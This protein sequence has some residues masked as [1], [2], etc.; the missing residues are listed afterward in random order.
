ISKKRPEYGTFTTFQKIDYFFSFICLIILA[1]TGL[2]LIFPVASAA[3]ISSSGLHVSLSIH[4]SF[5]ILFSVFILISHMFNTHLHP[6]K[7]YFNT[8]WLTGTLNEEEMKKHHILTY[9]KIVKQDTDLVEKYE[10][11]AEEKSQEV[12]VKKEQKMLED[13]LK[14]GNA[15]AQSGEYGQAVEKYQEA[16]VIYPNYS[17]AKFNLGVVYKKNDQLKEAYSA[18]K[19]FV[20]MDPFNE[21]A[22]RAKKSMKEIRELL[23]E[24]DK[25][26]DENKESDDEGI[27]G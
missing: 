3:F 22:E 10:K 25:A 23:A 13:Y 26:K 27:N 21:M 19:E 9:N 5:A 7:L 8:L 12:K 15:F 2:L 14:E 20:D 24:S 18:F 4:S 1:L 11:I 17:Q 16:I 6:D